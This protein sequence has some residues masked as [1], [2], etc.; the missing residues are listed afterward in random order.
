MHNRLFDYKRG[1]FFII[2]NLYNYYFFIDYLDS[3]FYSHSQFHNSDMYKNKWVNHM[4]ADAQVNVIIFLETQ[5]YNKSLPIILNSTILI[6][7]Y[8]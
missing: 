3:F 7:K 5:N 6:Y 8:K 1:F 4:F 2:Y